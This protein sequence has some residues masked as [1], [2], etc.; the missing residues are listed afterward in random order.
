MG[1]FSYW[2]AFGVGKWYRERWGYWGLNYENGCCYEYGEI[3]V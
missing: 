2:M 3:T 1:F